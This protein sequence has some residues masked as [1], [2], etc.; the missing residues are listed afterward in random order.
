MLIKILDD[1]KIYHDNWSVLS[2]VLSASL[3]SRCGLPSGCDGGDGH[4]IWSEVGNI[5]NKQ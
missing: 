5:M 4:Q 1:D 3:S 2:A